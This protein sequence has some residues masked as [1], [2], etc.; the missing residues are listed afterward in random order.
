[1]IPGEPPF[2]FPWPERLA[3]WFYGRRRFLVTRERIA[4]IW[5]AGYEAGQDDRERQLGS[6]GVIEPTPNPHWED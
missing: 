5:D 2:Q 6:A 1:M 3:A 4:D